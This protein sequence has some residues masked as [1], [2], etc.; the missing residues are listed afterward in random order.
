MHCEP[1]PCTKDSD[2][3][4]YCVTGT[5]SPILGQCNAEVP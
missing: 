3:S 4:G 1:R 2:C 5:C